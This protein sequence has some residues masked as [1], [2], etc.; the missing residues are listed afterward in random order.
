MD[1]NVIIVGVGWSVIKYIHAFL[2]CKQLG[3]V[4][5]HQCVVVPLKKTKNPGE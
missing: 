3:A 5:L 2:K 4:K 1:E